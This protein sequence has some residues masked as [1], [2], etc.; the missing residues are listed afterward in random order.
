VIPRQL[1]RVLLCVLIVAAVAPSA[2]SQ[3]PSVDPQ[4]L[5][6]QWS[7]SWVGAHN[8]RNN[9]KYYLTIE[10]VEGDKVF[11]K[12]ESSGKATSEG[13]VNGRLAG[14]TLTF[15]KTTLTVD[16]DSMQGTGEDTKITLT[17]EK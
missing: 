12:R 10:R 14:N 3:A 8:A 11:G 4:R 6:G 7:G 2:W 15:G 1:S 5:I 9:G 16:G 17:K 13:K